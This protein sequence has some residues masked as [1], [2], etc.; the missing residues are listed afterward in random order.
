MD[1][2]V[3]CNDEGAFA[4]FVYTGFVA[5]LKR[6]FALRCFALILLAWTGVDLATPQLCAADQG[7]SIGIAHLNVESSSS[8]H[9]PA[10]TDGDCF[11]CAHNVI[12]SHIVDL[13]SGVAAVSPLFTSVGDQT[14]S[15]SRALFR[16][17]QLSL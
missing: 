16:P 15:T 5:S 3:G 12:P 11:C 10:A 7:G 14:L 6:S 2:F 13:A 17:P 1:H 4:A 8:R 9:A